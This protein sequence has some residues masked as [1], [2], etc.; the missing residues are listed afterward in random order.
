MCGK[1][2]IYHFIQADNRKLD[3]Y[4]QTW[5]ATWHTLSCLRTSATVQIDKFNSKLVHIGREEVIGGSL[6][7]VSR[8]QLANH[9]LSTK[10]IIPG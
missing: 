9:V 5:D 3:K 7:S 2:Q 1:F 8:A 6:L 4:V 10:G